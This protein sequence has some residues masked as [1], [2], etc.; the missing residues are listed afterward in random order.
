MT[1]RFLSVAVLAL[2]AVLVAAVSGLGPAQAQDRGYVDLAVTIDGLAGSA[3]AYV[4]FE[5]LL[6]NNGKQTAYDVV[7]HAE[8][9]NPIGAGRPEASGSY[10]GV[11]EDDPDR[12][13]G[14]IWRID[15]V[16]G[17]S[18]H[19]LD[20]R[21]APFGGNGV[22]EYKANVSSASYEPDH[23]KDDNSDTAWQDVNRQSAS[24][25]AGRYG[26]TVAVSDRFPVAGNPFDFTVTVHKIT[27][28]Y[29]GCVNIGLTPGLTGGTET[30]DPDDH[31]MSYTSGG[32]CDAGGSGAVSG[33]FNVGESDFAVPEYT[34]TLPVTVTGGATVNEQ[35][36]TAEVFAIPPVGPLSDGYD[37]PADNRVEYCLGHPP[38]EVFDHGEVRTWTVFSCKEGVAANMCDASDD[39]DVRVLATVVDADGGSHTHGG[40]EGYRVLD[41]ATALI[42]VKDVPGRVFDSHSGSITGA[43]TVSWQTASDVHANFTG[44]RSGVKLGE[45]RAPINDYIANW[46]SWRATFRAS[47]LDGGAPPGGTHVRDNYDGTAYWFLTSGNSYEFQDDFDFPLD[48]TSSATTVYFLDFE[49]LGTYVVDYVADVKH[50]TID[51]DG[52]TGT[53]VFRGTGRT[54]FHIGPIAELGVGDGGANAEVEAGQVAFTVAGFNDSGDVYESGKIVVELPA[55]TTG[56]RTIPAGAGVF[57]DNADNTNPPTW[58]WDIHD[59]EQTGDRRRSN[60]LPAGIIVTLIVDG[61][62]AG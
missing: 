13:K 32:R 11:V 60:G 6:Y 33:T 34:M 5:V 38:V 15:E 50:A 14:V 41:N 18:Q 42:H 49:A 22:K 52:E 12:A 23:R 55:G 20:L 25:L 46:T 30:F 35:C 59:L 3:L 56:L 45:N 26:V 27:G 48:S 9:T 1:R 53:D 58:T 28:F 54:I 37:D 19:T 43:R 51:D 21:V 44:T 2:C 17:F 47:G 7:V 39:V 16:P 57:D 10:E 4:G 24:K 31:G 29:E 8:V 40:S 61:V 62:T 36:L